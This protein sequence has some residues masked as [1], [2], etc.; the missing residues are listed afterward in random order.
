LKESGKTSAELQNSLTKVSKSFNKI[1]KSRD[2]WRAIGIAGIIVTVTGGT[3][4][5]LTLALDL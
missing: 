3:V 1:Q 4:L 2:I 5:G